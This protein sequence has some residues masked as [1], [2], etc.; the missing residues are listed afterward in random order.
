MN[1]NHCYPCLKVH[2]AKKII[3]TARHSGKLKLT[4]TSPHVIS[5]S[6]KSFLKSRVD[7]TVLPLFEFL[8]KEHLPV[9]QVKNRIH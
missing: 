5:T 8:Q 3:F 1:N 2:D 4:F 7:L 6:P 9:G